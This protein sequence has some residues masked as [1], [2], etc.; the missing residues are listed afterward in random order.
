MYA[1][2][3]QMSLTIEEFDYVSEVHVVVDNDFTV[4]CDQGQGQKEDKVLRGNPGSHPDH[5]PHCEHI[6]IQE[7]YTHTHTHTQTHTNTHRGEKTQHF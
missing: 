4:N 5:L 1:H 6:L 3:M 2:T 7:L